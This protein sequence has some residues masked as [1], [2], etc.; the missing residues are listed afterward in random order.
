MARGAGWQ[1]GRPRGWRRRRPRGTPTARPSS[2]S[3]HARTAH[4]HIASARACAIPDDGPARTATP[5]RRPRARARPPAF[6]TAPLTHTRPHAPTRTPV[7]PTNTGWQFQQLAR[8]VEQFADVGW[9]R[10]K[11]SGERGGGECVRS[12]CGDSRNARALAESSAGGLGRVGWVVG[13]GWIVDWVGLGWV[14]L[15]WLGGRACRNGEPMCGIGLRVDRV[16]DTGEIW[17]TEVVPG[18]P[19]PAPA[20]TRRRVSGV[21]QAGARAHCARA[22]GDARTHAHLNPATR[23]CTLRRRRRPA[24]ADPP[25]LASL[26]PASPP[27]AAHCPPGPRP[28]GP[29][30]VGSPA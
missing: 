20:R 3:A 16:R 28:P 13:L 15:G 2:S 22:R 26:R 9:M 29:K 24:P 12:R 23:S 11:G 10:M 14:G 17:I 1:G 7:A 25:A 8:A 21:Q 6:H 19:A 27:R 18:R 30:S 5:C 4:A